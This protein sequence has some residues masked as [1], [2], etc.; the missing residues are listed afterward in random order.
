MKQAPFFSIVIPTYNRAHIIADSLH[1][2]LQQEFTDWEVIVIDD[3]ST[4]NTKEIVESFKETKF[5]YFRNEK[6]VERSISR[7]RGIEKS[8]G[9][10]ICFLDSDDYFLPNHLSSLH[11]TILVQ[12]NPIAFY[13]SDILTKR[14]NHLEKRIREDINKYGHIVPYLLQNFLIPAQ[15][16]MHINILKEHKFDENVAI[17][18]IEDFEFWLRIAAQF[19]VVPTNLYT[20]VEVYHDN[21]ST[22]R[23]NNVAINQLNGLDVIFSNITISKHISK[24]LKDEAYGARYYLMAMYYQYSGEKWSMIKSLVKS[25][26]YHPTH[27]DYKGKLVMLLYAIPGIK[28]LRHGMRIKS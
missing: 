28:V 5:Q 2:I 3:A 25:F 26:L 23:K 6:N 19:P 7:N 14:N 24:N 16:C 10:Y 18:V 1:S 20:A 11:Q 27:F 22:A 15:V 4:D 9:T 21:N 8:R 13:F 17:L 12:Q